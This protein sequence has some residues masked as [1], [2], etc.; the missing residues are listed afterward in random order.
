[1]KEQKM[2]N[3]EKTFAALLDQ[4]PLYQKAETVTLTGSLA[5]SSEKGKFALLQSDGS[6]L[7]LETDAV[8]S[9]RVI[10]NSFGQQIV[11][12]ELKAEMMPERSAGQG[13]VPNPLFPPGFPPVPKPLYSDVHQKLPW[14]DH[15]KHPWFDHRKFPWVDYHPSSPSDYLKSSYDLRRIK[16]V[17]SD[18]TFPGSDYPQMPTP[19]SSPSP[20]G[21]VVTKP[22]GY[23]HGYDYP[24]PGYGSIGPR[25]IP[26]PLEPDLMYE[27]PL[28]S[29]LPFLLATGHQA[30]PS[31]LTQM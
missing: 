31:A 28:A 22:N 8:K 27:N 4:A 30:P 16:F 23:P 15:Y 24:H 21:P 5:R 29:Y 19:G 14:L 12:I 1:M 25:D 17:D 11:Q 7:D 9:H 18:L 10:G 6:V 13:P 2:T 26:T 3:E 20:S